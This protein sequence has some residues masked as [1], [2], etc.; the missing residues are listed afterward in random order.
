V[1][2]NKQKKKK[3]FVANEKK[4]PKTKKFEYQ[5]TETKGDTTTLY[6]NGKWFKQED[7]YVA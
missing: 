4:N 2:A 5:L 6:Q 3:L 1:I 7:V